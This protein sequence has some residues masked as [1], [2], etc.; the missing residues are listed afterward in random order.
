M[1]TFLDYIK[2]RRSIYGI[3]KASPVSD[4]TLENIVSE[5]I[6]HVP[7]SFNSQ[8][9]RAVLLLGSEH[10]KLWEIVFDNIKTKTPE[11]KLPATRK[12]IDGFKA[13]YGTVLFY[14]HTPTVKGLQ[15]KFPLYAENFGLWAHHSEGMI[16]FVIWTALE[17]YGLGASIQHYN[18]LIDIDVQKA[19]AIPEGWKLVAQMPFGTPTVEPGVKTFL[20]IEDRFLVRK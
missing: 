1:S 7:S 11:V 9:N 5:A 3:S 18:P 20:P 8:S 16:Q 17:S 15:E 10:D 4:N 2:T 14:T 13:G 6:L 19:Y 12:K